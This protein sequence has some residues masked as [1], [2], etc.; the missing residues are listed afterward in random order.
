LHLKPPESSSIEFLVWRAV[1]EAIGDGHIGEK[2]EYAALHSQ[3]V[4]IGIQEGE[5]ALG[6]VGGIASHGE[7]R[8]S[9][10]FK[11]VDV[12]RSKLPIAV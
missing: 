1:G 4:E 2:L 8:E 10:A 12:V 11:K 5:Y 6:Q 9:Y 7:S 3:L